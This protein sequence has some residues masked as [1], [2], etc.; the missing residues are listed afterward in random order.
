MQG[1]NVMIQ[2]LEN[3]SKLPNEWEYLLGFKTQETQPLPANPAI[4]S[5]LQHRLLIRVEDDQVRL[6]VP[7]MQMWM[8]ERA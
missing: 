5:S 2:L 1:D 6:R 4:V 3:E 7:L 8:Q